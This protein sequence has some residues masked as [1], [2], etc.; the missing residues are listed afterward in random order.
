M[1]GNE[2]SRTV[3][4]VVATAL[5]VAGTQVAFGH[6]GGEVVRVIDALERAGIRF[7]VTH[8]EETAV[9]MAMGFGEYTGRP[10]ISVATIG[11]G[12]ANAVGGVAAAFLERAPVVA[13]TATRAP[14]S[15]PGSAHQLLD[16]GALFGPISK[17]SFELS[18][19]N[20]EESVASAMA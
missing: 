4:D 16:L 17:A 18:S 1:A 11:P 5:A 6:P 9:F 8:H 2:G 12:A 7:V 14:G 20:A 19:E 15:A 3:A 13:L 10:G